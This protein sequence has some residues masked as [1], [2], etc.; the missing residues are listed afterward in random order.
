M[1]QDKRLRLG[2]LARIRLIGRILG[3]TGIF[4]ALIGLFILV[5]QGQILSVDALRNTLTSGTD[6]LRIAGFMVIGGAGLAALV[7]LF[8]ILG[9]M[10]GSGQRSISGL[11]SALQVALGIA[12]FGGVNYLAFN[13]FQRWDLTRDRDFTLPPNVVEELRK[14]QGQTTIVVLQQ[15]KTFG[16]LS[17]KPDV[18]DYAAE[19]KVVEK[20]KDLVEQFRLLGPQFRVVTL[21]VEAIGYD[22]RLNEETAQRPGLK[23]AISAAPDNS[24][25][26]YADDRVEKLSN[27]EALRRQAAGRRVST[28]PEQGS[29]VFA[30]EG[31]IPR[32]SFNEF[33]QL[34]KS[35]SK[36]ANPSDNGTPR[37]NLILHPQGVELFIRNIQN[38]QERRP[39]VGLMVIHEVLTTEMEN[40]ELDEFSAHGL[41]KS[42]E[43]H[44]FD[45]RDILLKR[46]P[47]N[48]ESTAAA[49]NTEET[50]FERLASEL[51]DIETELRGIREENEQATAFAKVFQEATLE[52]LNKQFRSR[53][54]RDIDEAFRQRQL[55]VINDA[56]RRMKE[57]ASELSKEKTDIEAKIQAITKNERAFEDRRVTDL[58]AKMTRLVSDCDLLVIP[59]HTLFNL[60]DRRAVNPSLYKLSPEQV[61]VTRAFMKAGKPI[62]A[63]IGPSN[64]PNGPP[65]LEPLDEFERLLVDRGI[66]L[67]R[68][69]VIYDV[70][71]KAFS[72]R[73]SGSMLGGG[74][75]DEIPPVSFPATSIDQRQPNPIAEAMLATMRSADMPLNI[76]LRHPRP[77]Y[78]SDAVEEKLPFSP[79]F[80]LTSGASWNE[81][82]PFPTMRPISPGEVA[83]IPPR[84]DA[85]PFDDPKKGTHDEERRGP[86]TVGV[87]IESPVPMNWFDSSSSNSRKINETLQVANLSTPFDGGLLAAALTAQASLEVDRSTGKA[88]RQK[89]RPTSRMVVIGQG[90]VFNGIHLNPAQEQLLLHSCNWLLHR[91][92]RL[93]RTDLEWKYPRV[94][95]DERK[96][97]L[98]SYAP[99]FGPPALFLYL[100]VI[101]LL[102]RRVR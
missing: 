66:E 83:V 11:N 24:V 71:K 100:G 84:Y 19:R 42:L 49:Y 4:A 74:T 97:F 88:I 89:E 33:Y 56:L 60:S 36:A 14:L 101:V 82:Q 95:L 7:V 28:R 43:D 5:S 79:A 102:V 18:Y 81:S 35:A 78:I 39:R 41:R 29:S 86:F 90:G 46:W 10:G 50:K 32:L 77:I 27:T 75:S 65:L 85:T 62:L 67:G 23:E 47:P 26:F 64:E 15:H 51:E 94:N 70:E 98:W 38:I 61:K 25:F 76:T 8:E 30:Y 1:K 31:N 73:R 34:D 69:A 40:K 55:K 96:S 21:D 58:E 12:L 20:V 59:R 52:Q 92:D 57:R 3:I 87:A 91:D 63:C 80:M 99:L 72:A 44:G 48:E 13:Y 17:P 37:G 9:V 54:R 93:P 2:W 45:V 16:Q 68:Q 6:L 53:I 22:K